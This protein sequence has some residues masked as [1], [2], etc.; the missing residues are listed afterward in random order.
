MSPQHWSQQRH[1]QGLEMK[2]KPAK[3]STDCDD[4]IVTWDTGDACM[5]VKIDRKTNVGTFQMAPGYEA[6][7]TFL[8]E[9]ELLDKDDDPLMACDVGLVSDDETSVTDGE[10][11]DDYDWN[12]GWMDDSS[13]GVRISDVPK[14]ISFDLTPEDRRTYEVVEPDEE[15]KQTNNLS[16]EI[17]K[18]RSGKGTQEDYSSGS[19]RVG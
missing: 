7:K 19:M 12:E 13:E 4:M 11:P 14:E 5:T 3:V 16:A 6:Y 17:L 18:A 1:A 10:H 8:Q 9:A 15:D 2:H